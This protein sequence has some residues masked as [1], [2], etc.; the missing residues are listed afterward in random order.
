MRRYTMILVALAIAIMAFA[1]CKNGPPCDPTTE[2]DLNDR[3]RDWCDPGNHARGAKID[4]ECV[5]AS[6]VDPSY[7]EPGGSSGNTTN[8]TTTVNN[9]NNTTTVNNTTTGAGGSTNTTTTTTTGAGGGTSGTGTITFESHD[10]T[11]KVQWGEFVPQATTLSFNVNG[12]AT[13][14]MTAQDVLNVTSGCNVSVYNYS[15]PGWNEGDLNNAL[16]ASASDLQ[17]VTL[18]IAQFN[19]KFGT[20]V[21]DVSCVPTQLAPTFANDQPELAPMFLVEGARP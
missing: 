6:S 15:H 13:F 11:L 2:V 3:C 17:Q 10:M 12:G 20:F 4:G 18:P 16:G 21:V 19:G 8:N 9:T 14:A 7:H 5:S 1:S